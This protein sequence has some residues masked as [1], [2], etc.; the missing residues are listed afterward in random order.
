M[1]TRNKKQGGYLQG[2]VQEKRVTEKRKESDTEIEGERVQRS[3]QR[4]IPVTHSSKE[5]PAFEVPQHP[6]VIAPLR[7]HQHHEPPESISYVNHSIYHIT[8]Q[9]QRSSIR[10]E[11][12]E[13]YERYTIKVPTSSAYHSYPIA[14][15][16]TC[17]RVFCS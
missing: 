15:Q 2:G 12:S 8:H 11:G 14:F 3:P 5:A 1:T 17:S 9:Y 13:G 10:S 16:R 4:H 7:S 6:K